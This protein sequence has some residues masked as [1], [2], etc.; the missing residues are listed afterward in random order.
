MEIK[1]LQQKID[2]WIKTIGVRYF[3]VMTNTLILN[4]EVGEFSRLV[5]RIY[6]EQSFKIPL[7][8]EEQKLALEDELADVIWVSICLANQMGINLE[9]AI[10]R[11]I[12]K[13]TN[14]D[15]NRH[16]NNDKLS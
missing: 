5:A 7:S 1:D 9:D 11:N 12:K 15:Q 4:E 2:H 8:E 3:D 6:G 14:R 10:Q 16:R 13:K